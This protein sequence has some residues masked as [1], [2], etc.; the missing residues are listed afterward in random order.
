MTPVFHVCRKA[1]QEKDRLWLLRE[2]RRK[3]KLRKLLKRIKNNDTC[4]MPGLTCFTHDNQHW[5]TAPL[6]TRK[7]TGAARVTR[8]YRSAAQPSAHRAIRVCAGGILAQKARELNEN[9]LQIRTC[10]YCVQHKR[11]RCPRLPGTAGGSSGWRCRRGRAR[12][13]EPAPGR[14][15]CSGARGEEP[16]VDTQRPGQTGIVTVPRDSG[17][18]LMVYNFNLQ[19]ALSVP[20]PAP[21]TTRTGVWG[22]STRPT[23]S[24]FVNLLLDFW[25]ILISIPIHIRYVIMEQLSLFLTDKVKWCGIGAGCTL[26]KAW[27]L[28]VVWFT[29]FLLQ[30]NHMYSI[31]ES[32][33]TTEHWLLTGAPV[34][35]SWLMRWIRSIET[36]SI[37]CTS[38]SWN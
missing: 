27:S 32:Y 38:S 20:V 12:R 23:T 14:V 25:S 1:L 11:V 17:V 7:D 22:Q 34:Y 19:W 18:Q 31:Y 28:N 29:S 13:T 21:T 33:Q 24:C 15:L 16:C 5:Q 2:Q 35:R 4:S 10:R 9:R 8:S 26:D 37:N 6:W 30:V 3:K 36:F